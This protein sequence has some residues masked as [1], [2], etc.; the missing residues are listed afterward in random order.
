MMANLKITLVGAGSYVWTPGVLS[1]LLSNPRLNGCHIMMHDLNPEALE[2]GYRL[3]MRYKEVSGTACTFERTTDAAAALDG[4]D[5]VTVTISTGGLA[6]QPD[7][8]GQYD[9]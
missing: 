5:F 6:M 7:L 9:P 3:A 1:N 4:A 8:I 2:L